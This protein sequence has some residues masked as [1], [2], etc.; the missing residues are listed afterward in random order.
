MT[1]SVFLTLVVCTVANPEY[2]F[3]AS[4][5]CYPQEI[6]WG[7]HIYVE[8]R[9]K[10]IG[11]VPRINHQIYHV[12]AGNVALKSSRDELRVDPI[13]SSPRGNNMEG[14]R[15]VIAPNQ[16]VVVG[17]EVISLPPVAYRNDPFWLPAKTQA[18]TFRLHF[19]FQGESNIDPDQIHEC[20]IRIRPLGPPALGA[21]EAIFEQEEAW[22]R[23]QPGR[24]QRLRPGE[25]YS[26]LTPLVPYHWQGIGQQERVIDKLLSVQDKLP[27]GT[28]RNSISYYRLLKKFDPS[29]PQERSLSLADGSGLLEFLDQTKSLEQKVIARDAMLRLEGWL[30]NRQITETRHALL[31]SVRKRLEKGL[32]SGQFIDRNDPPPALQPQ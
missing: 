23:K 8:Y 19:Q 31:L 21:L 4:V 14:Q 20:D 29:F 15:Q 6:H 7:D 16:E 13:L 18:T 25:T 32:K 2:P 30:S 9:L 26:S 11:S 3:V 17:S 27:A 22:Q 24:L 28:L 1:S 12:S 5:T 10:N